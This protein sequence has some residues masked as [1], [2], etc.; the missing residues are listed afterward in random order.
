MN[1]MFLFLLLFLSLSGF[2]QDLLR[3]GLLVSPLDEEK[4]CRGNVYL[5]IS[6]SILKRC[7]VRQGQACFTINSLNL[8][9]YVIAIPQGD[10]SVYRVGL[11]ALLLC[12]EPI[13]M[14]SMKISVDV[15]IAD[16]SIDEEQEVIHK[17]NTYY[18]ISPYRTKEDILNEFGELLWYF[19]TEK[20]IRPYSYYDEFA[21]KNIN[22]DLYKSVYG[23]YPTKKD[24]DSIIK[25]QSFTDAELL[26]G[27]YSD[28]LIR[29]KEPILCNGYSQEVFRFTW[30][31]EA[32]YHTYDPYC[33]RIE[34]DNHGGAMLYFSYLKWDICE[35]YSLYCD[36]FL[37][38]QATYGEF[39]KI[40]Q[41]TALWSDMPILDD[42]G[43]NLILE[44]NVNG[45][46]H[47]IFRG[48]GEDEGMEELREFLWSLTGL[49]ENKIVHR[50]Q[51]IE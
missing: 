7:S 18:W 23:H 48:E 9:K 21:S 19:P 29:L 4:V 14:R 15:S 28:R 49:G 43:S 39:C 3:I 12:Q 50:R 16:K 24:I 34:P 13:I 6:D 41:D 45:Q 35:E 30:S 33:M 8:D 10:G 2:S 42:G 31:S 5:C 32:A 22:F 17:P 51:R 27:W 37:M 46:Y 36:L 26:A 38:D 20:L 1:K 11:S 44:A 40:I 25:K 47:V